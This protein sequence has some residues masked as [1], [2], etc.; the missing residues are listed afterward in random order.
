M[1]NRIFSFDLDGKPVLGFD[2]GLNPQAFAQAKMAQFITQPGFI[3][4]PDGKIEAW[5][6]K[7]VTEFGQKPAGPHAKTTMVVWGPHFPGEELTGIINDPPARKDEALNALRFWIRARTIV[8]RNLGGGA[9]PPLPGPAGTLYVPHE[10]QGPYQ[11]GTVF[12]PPP[13][14]LK[15]SVEADDRTTLEA[16][17]WVHPDLEGE[18]GISFSAG[19]MLY[20]I[21]CGVPPFAGDEPDLLRQDIREGVF[22]PPHLAAPGL[23]PELSGLISRAMST[24][25]RN[26]EEKLRPAP[27]VMGNFI[28]PIHTKPAASWI[29]ALE[30]EE[31]AKIRAE[32]EQYSKKKALTVKTRRFVIRNTAIIAA[33]VIALFS[34]AL[35]VRGWFKHRAE[36]PTTRGMTPVEVAETYYGSFGDMDHTT[37]DACVTNKAGKG[38]I[39][40]VVN[41]YVMTRVRQAYETSGETYMSAQEWVDQGK[42]ITDKAVFGITDLNIKV[43]S[44]SSGNVV[45]DADYIL[46]MPGAYLSE[47]EGPPDMQEP[48]PLPPGGMVTSDRLDLVFKKDAWLISNI[49]RTSST[50]SK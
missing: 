6:P 9:E 21:F 1:S 22:I 31:I 8:E 49:D 50:I 39:E 44:E 25:A 42:P 28:G 36:L 18:E 20:R 7:G 5:Q 48:A 3:V 16:G 12:F 43:L 14:L 24:V 29:K 33:I 10:N 27:D 46:W 45:L 19:A 35:F 30:E 13:R 40:M 23:D 2:T 41:L 47:H 37:M 26:R 17:R 11:M 4:Y 32:Q 38:D 15:R 34:S